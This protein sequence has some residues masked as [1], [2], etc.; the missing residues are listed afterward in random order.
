MAIYALNGAAPRTGGA[1]VAPD[2]AIIGDVTLGAGA[3]V[4]F[5]A[6]LRGD[7]AP[8][9][10]G[11]GCNIQDGCILHVDADFPLFLA[12]EVTVGHRAVLHGCS[13]GRRCLVGIGAIILNGAEIGRECLIGAGALVGEGAKIPDRSLVLGVPGRIKRQIT[14]AEAEAFAASAQEYMAKAQRYREELQIRS[15]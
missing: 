8:I 7:N 12:E 5:G 15:A 2:A 10:I 1:W 4:W 6:V 14:A 3:S 9:D 11:A 13:I